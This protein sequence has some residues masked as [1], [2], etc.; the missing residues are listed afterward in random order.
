MFKKLVQVSSLLGAVTAQSKSEAPE[1]KLPQAIVDDVKSD[2][3]L[4][5]LLIDDGN[6]KAI[7]Y[8][9]GW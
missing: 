9:I 7:I 4:Q 1:I 2:G 6:G 5:E 3:T 8:W